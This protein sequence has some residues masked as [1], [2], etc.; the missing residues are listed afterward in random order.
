MKR[1][2]LVLLCLLL[3]LQVGCAASSTTAPADPTTPAESPVSTPVDEPAS[4][5]SDD[6]PSDEL[7]A[8]E[9]AGEIAGTPATH[10]TGISSDLYYNPDHPYWVADEMQTISI[11]VNYNS[12]IDGVNTPN[13]SYM[14]DELEAITNVHVEWEVITKPESYSVM[15]ASGEYTDM[16][17]PLTNYPGGWTKGIEDGIA[18]DLTDIVPTY[19]P[20]YNAL[21]NQNSEIYKETH[22]DNGGISTIYSIVSNDFAEINP[23][24]QPWGLTIRE[25]W[26]NDLGLELP[27]TIADWDTVLQALKDEKGATA[28]LWLNN[29]GFAESCAF[30]SA[31]GCLN[32]FYVDLDGETIK[33]GPLQEGYLKYLTLMSDWYQRGLIPADFAG[34]TWDDLMNNLHNGISG[35]GGMSGAQ[36]DD[37][38]LRMGFTDDPDYVLTAVT[39]PVENEGDVPQRGNFRSYLFTSMVMTVDCENPEYPARWLD[40]LYTY[41]GMLLANFGVEGEGYYID[42][43]GVIRQS[44]LYLSR[45]ENAIFATDSAALCSLGLLLG[46]NDTD[47][48]NKKLTEPMIE[49]GAIFTNTSNAMAMPSRLSLT[50]SESEIVAEKYSDIQTYVSEMTCRYIMGLSSL[51]EYDSFIEELYAMGIED[52]IAAYQAAY[53][54]YM[55]R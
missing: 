20:N 39:F 12:G 52:C 50:L 11:S 21:I 10:P 31:Y 41:E 17:I 4:A 28:P 7:P 40:Y 6:A 15:L 54:R 24:I 51:D 14:I 27:V 38:F 29:T 36:V 46:L 2:S 35:A 1:M 47:T 23:A 43:D 53:V 26:L 13:D 32:E 30:L 19:M 49:D 5:T 34:G 18:V 3:L 55:N 42:D 8:E 37:W 16:I 9:P 48:W 22:D 45:P 33:Y 44:E 25:D